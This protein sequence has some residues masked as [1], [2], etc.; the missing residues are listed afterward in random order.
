VANPPK[1]S[2]DQAL[3]IKPVEC[4]PQIPNC[5]FLEYLAKGTTPDSRSGLRSNQ[6]FHGHASTAG[7]NP[8]PAYPVQR[9]ILLSTDCFYSWVW[10]CLVEAG[11][12]RR[13]LGNDHCVTGNALS[14]FFQIIP[15][16]PGFQLSSSTGLET[17]IRHRHMKTGRRERIVRA[18]GQNN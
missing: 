4:K 15:G 1:K 16:I 10:G 5:R 8:K 6:G 2:F 9:A 3:P 11:A 13:N 7:K 18:A 12:R 14:G 17:D